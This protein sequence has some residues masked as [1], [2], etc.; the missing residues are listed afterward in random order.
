[1]SA[2]RTLN[3]LFRAF[4]SVGPGRLNDPGDTGTITFTMWGQICSIVTTAAET[5]TL[6]Q[7]TKP[8]VLCAVVLDTD[9][10]DLTLTVT[11]GYN[12]SADTAIVLND[13]GDFVQFQS[14][15]VGTSY[16]WRVVGYEGADL[17]VGGDVTIRGDIFFAQDAPV[18]KADGNRI[19]AGPD[20]VNKI[21][22]HTVTAAAT[23]TTPAGTQIAANM[24]S[25]AAVGDSFK[26]HVI[27]IGAGA[28]DISTLTAGDADVTLVGDVT[29]GP[30][31][32]GTNGF[33]TWIFRKT[34]A[35]SFVGYRI[36]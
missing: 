28:D 5:R 25:A 32:A 27:T 26:L 18:A 34:G 6:A 15:K 17:A 19:I 16:L 3:D 31:A 23:L 21:I 14:V 30:A 12:A 10:G 13:A 24:S 11:G 1:M 7:P 2:H 9:G 20:F 33:A 4:D 35:T 36:G 29:V 8:G 22:V